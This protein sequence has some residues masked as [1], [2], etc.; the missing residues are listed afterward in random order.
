VAR[1]HGYEEYSRIP[2]QARILKSDQQQFR[3]LSLHTIIDLPDQN[4]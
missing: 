2:G 4:G 1:L 3:I